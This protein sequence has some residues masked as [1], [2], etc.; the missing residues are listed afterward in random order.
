MYKFPELDSAVRSYMLEELELDIRVGLFYESVYLQQA[1]IPAYQQVLYSGFK[2]GDVNTIINALGSYF[3]K[4]E[5][6]NRKTPV[7]IATTLAF[8]DFNRY[9]MRAILKKAIN[10]SKNVCIYRAKESG[11][12]RSE[13]GMLIG[14]CYSSNEAEVMLGIM[15]DYRVL[16]KKPLE[17]F[18]P[19]S[20]LS[21][22]TI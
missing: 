11:N 18:K 1:F 5:V 10:E 20:G 16:F 2:N 9:Y 4:R 21:L 14:R 8:N 12:Q 22:K 6:N 7:N 15:Q 19:N 3:F 13:S 17:F